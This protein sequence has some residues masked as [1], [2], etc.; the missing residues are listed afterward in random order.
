MKIALQGR[1]TFCRP[2]RRLD[3]LSIANELQVTALEIEDD[4][5]VDF[6]ELVA[7][8][9]ELERCRIE[10]VSLHAPCSCWTP[11]TGKW[12]QS[13][14]RIELAIERAARIGSRGVVLVP[15]MP[16]GLSVEAA[17]DGYT[18]LAAAARTLAAS[19]GLRLSLNNSGLHAAAFG[20]PTYFAEQCDTLAPDVQMTMDV[21]NWQLG[22]ECP[23]HAIRVL[24][25]W[26]EV[27]HLKDWT[28]PRNQGAVTSV[29]RSMA[30]A[31]RRRVMSSPFGHAA[32][33]IATWLGVAR[34]VPRVVQGT[35]G[36]WYQGAMIG[37]GI[38][39]LKACL[40][41]LHAIKF[42]GTLV[43]EYEGTGDLAAAYRTGAA[44]VR[45]ML[46]TIVGS[47][48]Q[49]PLDDVARTTA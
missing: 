20:S 25:P 13:V 37:D 8:R 45:E 18:H 3:L 24:A 5:T 36:T 6:T 4:L 43:I 46:S 15:R 32:R 41:A 26:L 1:L 33:Q 44:K 14:Q 9:R 38:V 22:G 17:R 47:A 23:L 7:I 40:Q 11:G 35:D 48:P 28:I 10:V 42:P 12:A 27:I 19:H 30:M 49:L 39:D 21:A 34:Q 29:S 16:R 31:I 2:N